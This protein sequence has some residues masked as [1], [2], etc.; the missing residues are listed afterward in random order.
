[1]LKTKGYYICIS[2]GDIDIRRTYFDHAEYEWMI[3]PPSPYKVFKPNITQ[4]DVEF[5]EKDKE[6]N[7]DHYHYIYILQKVRYLDIAACRQS[8]AARFPNYAI[9]HPNQTMIPYR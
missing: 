4:A 8:N 2:Y 5:D 7:K 1:M 3:L 9:K 6:K